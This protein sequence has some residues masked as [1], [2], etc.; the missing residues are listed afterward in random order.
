MRHNKTTASKKILSVALLL[1]VWIFVAWLLFPILTINSLEYWN[2][3]T[4]LYRT[5]AAV[6]IMLILFGKTIFDLFFPIDA[7]KR[8]SL[9]NT[10]F[11]TVYSIVILIGIFFIAGRLIVFYFKGSNT[12]FFSM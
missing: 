12:E 11:L 1:I 5:V 2:V 3:K 7:S 4:Y 6:A 10:I 9:I 8:E